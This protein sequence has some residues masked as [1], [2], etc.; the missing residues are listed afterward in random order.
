M[1]EVAEW[2]WGVA[3]LATGEVVMVGRRVGSRVL[4]VLGAAVVLV[5]GLLV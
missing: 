1:V 3:G 2:V 4:V 5:T